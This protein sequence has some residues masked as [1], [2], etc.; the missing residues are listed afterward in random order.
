MLYF[1]FDLKYHNNSLAIK[2]SNAPNY[3]KYATKGRFYRIFLVKEDIEELLEDIKETTKLSD[4]A[5]TK[6]IEYMVQ[7]YDKTQWGLINGITEVAQEFTL[8]RRIELE[9]LAGNMLVAV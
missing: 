8:E 4:E 2:Y 9:T 1:L 5:A 7:K 3:F 6:V